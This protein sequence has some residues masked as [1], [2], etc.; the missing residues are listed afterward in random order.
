MQR[1]FIPEKMLRGMRLCSAIG[2]IPSKTALVLRN[3]K[4]SHNFCGFSRC[5]KAKRVIYRIVCNGDFPQKILRGMRPCS[6]IRD[7]P[8]KNRP[9]FEKSEKNPRFL[10]FFSRCVKAKRVINRIGCR[11]DFS[12]K[13]CEGCG[14]VQQSGT[15]PAKTRSGFEK[16]E[17]NSRFSRFF[18]VAL[19]QNA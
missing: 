10:R 14:Y 9:S 16:F 12:K 13:H 3:L 19:K 11:E 18:L 8:R 4:K 1:G 7:S 17:K 15:A 5:I 6:A 2:T